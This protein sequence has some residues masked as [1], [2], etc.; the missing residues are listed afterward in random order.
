MRALIVE[1][2]QQ[3]VNAL[4]Q[5]LTDNCPEIKLCGQ[6]ATVHDAE[7]LIQ[8]EKPDIVFLDIQLKDGTGFELLERLGNYEFKVIF[9]TAYG[10]YALQAIKISALDY[11]LKP[12]ETEELV[13]AVNKA[14]SIDMSTMNEQILNLIRNQNTNQ[15]RKKI[16]LPTSKGISIHEINSIL[17]IQAEGNYSGIYLDSGKRIIVAKTL[18]EFE[19]MLTD[20]GFIRIHHSHII[21]MDHL[22]SYISKDGGYVVMR[23]K[24]S[25]P[26]SKRKKP[27][28]LKALGSFS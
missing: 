10:Q 21:N 9:T 17:R 3:A 27:G 18:K 19:D 15:P 28:L 14:R 24:E 11:L 4:K 6:A 20:M 16:A 2:E 5:E 23:N 8:N 26:V 1:D 13:M 12:V 7:A 25:L 22:D